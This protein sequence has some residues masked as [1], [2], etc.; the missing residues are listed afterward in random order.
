MAQLYSSTLNSINCLP[1][2]LISLK[3]PTYNVMFK[4]KT[5]FLSNLTIMY[6]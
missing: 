1:K 4:C 3:S 5:S 2:N 6:I